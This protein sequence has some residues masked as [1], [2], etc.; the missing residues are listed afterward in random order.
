MAR[1]CEETYGHCYVLHTVTPTFEIPARYLPR[2]L[3]LRQHRI[4]VHPFT[5]LPESHRATILQLQGTPMRSRINQPHRDKPLAFTLS[6]K[7]LRHTIPHKI[8]QHSLIHLWRQLE[9]GTYMDDL[10]LFRVVGSLGLHEHRISNEMLLLRAEVASTDHTYAYIRLRV[11]PTHVA[12]DVA[13]VLTSAAKWRR[14]MLE[15]VNVWHREDHRYSHESKVALVEV[16][17]ARFV[18]TLRAQRQL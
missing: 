2:P 3:H 5:P 9:D 4:P 7:R 8:S 11:H 10:P 1:W 17:Y 12:G 18:I 6:N 14:D 16:L 15:R 13:F